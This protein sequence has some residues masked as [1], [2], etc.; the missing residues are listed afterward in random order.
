MALCW[1]KQAGVPSFLEGAYAVL[2]RPF[3][4]PPLP[5]AETR[6]ARGKKI[7]PAGFGGA[8]RHPSWT[9][10]TGR[11]GRWRRQDWT[12]GSQKRA[13]ITELSSKNFSPLANVAGKKDWRDGIPRGLVAGKISMPARRSPWKKHHLFWQLPGNPASVMG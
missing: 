4:F 6:L 8:K 5:F 2:P 1:A 11:I 9:S 12:E 3:L 13:K 10:K 7:N